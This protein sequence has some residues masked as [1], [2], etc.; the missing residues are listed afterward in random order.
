MSRRTYMTFRAREGGDPRG[1]IQFQCNLTCHRCEARS[2]S[3]GTRCKNRVCIGLPYCWLHTRKILKLDVRETNE[4]NIGKG[5]F[6]Y[7]PIAK[8]EHRPVFRKNDII[9]GYGPTEILTKRQLGKRYD[10][11][12]YKP[13]APYALDFYDRFEEDEM[14]EPV[15]DSACVR[16]V[17]SLINDAKGRKGK[18]NN[19]TF[20]GV[21]GEL[22]TNIEALEPIWHGRELLLSYGPA[23]WQA[24]LKGCD[25]GQCLNTQTVRTS[26]IPP[27]PRPRVIYR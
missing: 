5:V 12:D 25:G 11:A 21:P 4:K 6:A 19:V 18:H 27:F 17:A 23:Y 7:D 22:I 9:V 8:K 13:T 10:Y 14:D 2:E 20:A 1:R 16:G 3:T 15:M 24:Y 26:K